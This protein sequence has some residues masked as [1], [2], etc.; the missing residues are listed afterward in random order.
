MPSKKKQAKKN[1]RLKKL[2]KQLNVN[3]NT[4]KENLCCNDPNCE[5]NYE[6]ESREAQEERLA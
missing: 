2:K 4:K 1:K 5:N 3:R 6:K